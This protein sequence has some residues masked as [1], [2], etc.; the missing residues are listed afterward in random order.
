MQ[1]EIEQLYQKIAHPIQDMALPKG[2]EIKGSAHYLD[3]IRGKQIVR[4]GIRHFVYSQDI[5]NS[6][7]YYFG[8][9]KPLNFNGSELVDYSTGRYHDVQDFELMPIFFPSLSEPIVTTHQYLDFAALRPGVSVLDLGAYSGLTS[10]IFK[11]AV[12]AQGR[13][14][15]VDA[16]TEN[17]LAIQKNLSLYKKIS[18]M[19]IDLVH[20]AVWNHCNGLSF[21]SEGNM[22]SSASEI[23]GVERGINTTVKSLTLSKLMET[24]QLDTVDF[25]K[26]DVEGAEGVIFEDRAFFEKYRPRIIVETHL[27]AGRETTEK[28]ISDLSQYGYVCK[29][30][31]QTGV[32]LPLIECYPQ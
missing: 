15:A 28:C 5:I 3:F 8:S 12:G 18:G 24:A 2:I 21:S 16:D 20:S 31:D 23:V 30:I 7:D 29:R 19:D 10:I 4:L 25:I 27:V 17:V 22:G 9:V 14:V 13:V 32:T 11:E 26:C 1:T 6:F